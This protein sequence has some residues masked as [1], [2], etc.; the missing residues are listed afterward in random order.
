M[1]RK[2]KIRFIDSQ[3]L[4]GFAFFPGDLRSGI[5]RDVV[6]DQPLAAALLAN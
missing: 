3:D 1:T 5:G 6:K 4:S 2:E